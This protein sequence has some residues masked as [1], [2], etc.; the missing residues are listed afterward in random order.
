MEPEQL[1]RF[2]KQYR[3]L[4]L[5]ALD[6]GDAD[7]AVEAQRLLFKQYRMMER[8]LRRILAI[9]IDAALERYDEAQAADSE[10]FAADAHGGEADAAR[11][12]LDT[13]RELH[14]RFHNMYVDWT[15]ELLSALHE[16]YGSERFEAILR[17]TGEEF[18]E[19]FSQWARMSPEELLDASVFM[20]L[21]HPD[22]E[23]TVTE[24]DER[25]T[26]HQGCGTGGRLIA[27]GRFDGEDGLARI[28]VADPASLGA[29]GLPTYCAHCTVWNTVMTAER[30]GAPLW[31][32]D[33]PHDGSCSVHVYKD[34]SRTPSEYLQRL[35]RR[36][37]ET[38][39]QTPSGPS[40]SS[41]RPDGKGETYAQKPGEE[42][43]PAP[44]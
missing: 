23:L 20:Q 22:G 11:E 35:R 42:D 19:A 4:A 2:A 14:R 28:P 31:V 30:H 7:G 13:H 44:S 43:F 27:E 26:I 36:A 9:L 29:P 3:G 16:T 39:R 21:S 32:I 10:R 34:R 37:D 40:Y 41:E 8:S 38:S 15:A 25:Y 6:A 1:R 18:A 17:E 5:E 33:H 24:D 12:L